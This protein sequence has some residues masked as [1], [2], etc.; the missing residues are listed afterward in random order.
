[1]KKILFALSVCFAVLLV[2]ALALSGCG[3][4]SSGK[5][6]AKYAV[7]FVA[8]NYQSVSLVQEGEKA[9]SPENFK[10]KSG[11]KLD[12]WYT[13]EARTNYFEITKTAITSDITLYARFYDSDL[14]LTTSKTSAYV[15]SCKTDATEV[16]I[17]EI[18][19]GLSV[20]EIGKRA[21]HYLENLSFVEIPDSVN[22]IELE[23]FWYCTN[24]TQIAL[25][26]SINQIGDSAFACS[27]L[28]SV[29]IPK[30]VSELWHA[31]AGCA[32][33]E[34]VVFEGNI[35]K[36]SAVPED[37]VYSSWYSD[38]AFYNCVSLKEVEFKGT[39]ENIGQTTFY[40]CSSL[41]TINLPEGLKQICKAAFKG[42][43]A[44]KSIEI[45]TSA[46]YVGESAFQGCYSLSNISIP[47]YAIPYKYNYS[48]ETAIKKFSNLFDFLGNDEDNY[49]LMH[50][51]ISGEN[52]DDDLFSYFKK[53]ES[54]VLAEGVTTIGE[55]AFNMCDNLQTVELPHGLTSI[56]RSA[57]YGC[58]NLKQISIP[59]T[60]TEIGSSAFE[61][62]YSLE[63][64]NLPVG[65]TIDQTNDYWYNLLNYTFEYCTSLRTVT[66]NNSSVYNA[67][68]VRYYNS[69]R[70]L[71]RCAKTL[72]ILS[73]VVNSNTIINGKFAKIGTADEYNIYERTSDF[74]YYRLIDNS[75]ILTGYCGSNT[76]VT[77]PSSIDGYSVKK[78]SDEAFAECKNI[79]NITLSDS[80]TKIDQYAF[81]GCDNLQY[82]QRNGAKYLGSNTNPYQYLADIEDK[83]IADVSP[84][85]ED[86]KFIG[87]INFYGFENLTTIIIPSTILSIGELYASRESFDT[88]IIESESVYLDNVAMYNVTWYA[89]NTYV[90]KTFVDNN[91]NYSFSGDAVRSEGAGEYENYYI[92][93]R[94]D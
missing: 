25:P 58:H 33:L 21:F 31:F 13:N 68:N 85:L 80:L 15:K 92:F 1:M 77:I 82:N 51:E 87:D 50:V 47:A 14:T 74:S 39:L 83:T 79:T 6:S 35:T 19:H 24:L 66:I 16:T 9:K 17:P 72:K 91:P 55:Y 59:S 26:D 86:V 61:Y 48:Y 73:S 32:S 49:S 46:T 18:Y 37:D 7:T 34:K 65:Y 63:S 27:G 3:K 81:D 53:I 62:C 10:P 60:V 30:N 4:K 54:V 56:G 29:T 41:E 67:I 52:V 76:E 11:Q 2:P 20:T 78:F 71:I 38:G 43:S 90:P 84:Y 69:E 45:P 40:N 93:T 88:V 8:D 70:N 42:C 64:I 75:L 23:A 28:A 44:L 12:G 36:L 5:T 89:T 57:F 94:A 22:T